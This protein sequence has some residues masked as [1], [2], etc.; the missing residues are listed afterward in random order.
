MART[1]SMQ[2]ALF[3][4]LGLSLSAGCG[5]LI[6]PSG[7]Y[8]GRV[9]D[10]E[11]GQPI[12][13]LLAVEADAARLRRYQNAEEMAKTAGTRAIFPLFLAV[14]AIILLLIGP[15]VLKFADTPVMF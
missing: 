13:A 9:V 2:V 11:T 8:S 4:G 15:M 5:H 10:A 3:M 1:R 12:A 7:P 6:Y 14:I